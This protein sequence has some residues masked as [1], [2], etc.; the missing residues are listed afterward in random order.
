MGQIHKEQ[1]TEQERIAAVASMY[2]VSQAVIKTG[3]REIFDI[4]S[5]LEL[6]SIDIAKILDLPIEVVNAA[7][8]NL[9]DLNAV[10][11]TGSVDLPDDDE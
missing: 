9:E 4:A 3:N 2:A 5:G 1:L 11:V 6:E 7:L 10:E 8:S